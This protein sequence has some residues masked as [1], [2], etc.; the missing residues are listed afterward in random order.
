[1]RF[2]AKELS[3]LDLNQPQTHTDTHRLKRTGNKEMGRWEVKEAERL[4]TK[5][6]HRH[7]QLTTRIKHS[8]VGRMAN[9]GRGKMDER[10]TKKI[11]IFDFRPR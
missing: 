5:K 10:R 1:M 11:K 6:Y 2:E 9:E 4:K 7:R 8:E 3:C